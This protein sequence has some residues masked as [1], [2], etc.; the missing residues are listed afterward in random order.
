[1]F[2]DDAEPN[3]TEDAR[4]TAVIGYSLGWL[5]P[6]ENL[7]VAYPREVAREFPSELA[8]LAGDCQYRPDLGNYKD[9]CSSILLCNEVPEYPQATDALRPD[10]KAAVHEFAQAQR[11]R[12]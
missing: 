3:L 2:Y 8:E 6:Y 11:G 10:Q 1:M 7:W 5:K 9:Q 12:R 4:R